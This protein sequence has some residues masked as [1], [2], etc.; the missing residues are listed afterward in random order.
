MFTLTA[1]NCTLLLQLR[2]FVEPIDVPPAEQKVLIKK[3]YYLAG[4]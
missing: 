4:P 3:Y 1:D 2:Q